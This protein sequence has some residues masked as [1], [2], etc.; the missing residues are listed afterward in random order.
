MYGKL[1]FLTPRGRLSTLGLHVPMAMDP[2]GFDA[3]S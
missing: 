3:L 2:C 1:M